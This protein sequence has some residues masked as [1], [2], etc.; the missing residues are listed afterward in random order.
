MHITD[1]QINSHLAVRV[2]TPLSGNGIK[3]LPI[4][5]FYHGGGFAV[6]D[7][8]ADAAD[9]QY[10]AEHAGCVV[11]SVGYRLAPEVTYDDILQDAIA[12]YEW[13]CLTWT[14]NVELSLAVVRSR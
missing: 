9:A 12:G 14:L 10:F 11:V 6:G 3:D 8:D 5:V 13:V 4:G 2:F 1:K 7:L